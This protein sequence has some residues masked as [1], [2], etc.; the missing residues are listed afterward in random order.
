MIVVEMHGPIKEVC[1]DRFLLIYL[2]D[3][4]LGGDSLKDPLQ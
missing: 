2:L 4:S 1:G 3:I